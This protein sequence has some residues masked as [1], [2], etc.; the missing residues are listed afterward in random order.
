MTVRAH[1][2]VVRSVGGRDSWRAVCSCSWESEP[3]HGDAAEELGRAHVAE[4][5]TLEP[6]LTKLDLA[7]LRAVPAFYAE[8]DVAAS[9]WQIAETLDTT[10]MDDLLMTLGGFEQLDYVRGVVSRR[11]GRRVY[12]RTAKGDEAI[13]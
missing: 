5:S 8:G 2:Y 11:R 7:V 6:K 1:N 13:A 9:I 12:L 10:K 4:A 3:T